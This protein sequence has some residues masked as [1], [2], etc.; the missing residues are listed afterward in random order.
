MYCRLFGMNVMPQCLFRGVCAALVAVTCCRAIASAGDGPPLTLLVFDRPPYYLLDGGR[1]AGGFLL[2]NAMAVLDRAGLA[3][4][5]REMPPGRVLSTLAA[6]DVDACAVGWLET[7]E[8][9]DFARFSA[10]IYRNKPLIAALGA[11]SAACP[12]NAALAGLLA[13][14]DHWGL[15]NGFSYGP[16]ADALLATVPEERLHRF[17]DPELLLPLLAKGRLDAVL[18]EP[19]EFSWR[20]ARD[21]ALARTVRAC[22]LADACEGVTRHIMCDMTVPPETMARIDAAVG[23]FMGEAADRARVLLAQRH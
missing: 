4:V 20:M 8:R 2:V 13:A 7:P 15:R 21:A 11:T 12:Q 9:R 1:P 16:R 6:L 14:K 10:P 19:E 5:V 18:M 23:D 22:P 17:S 3:Y